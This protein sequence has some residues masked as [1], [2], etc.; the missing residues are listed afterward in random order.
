M[1]NVYIESSDLDIGD[2]D[3]LCFLKRIIP[4]TNL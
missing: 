3:N 1:T 4:D 2:G